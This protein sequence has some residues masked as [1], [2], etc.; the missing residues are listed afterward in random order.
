VVGELRRGYHDRLAAIHDEV[1]GMVRS[2]ASSVSQATDALLEGNVTGAAAV[3]TTAVALSVANGGVEREVFDLVALQAPVARDL[4]LLL[5]SLRV[6]HEVELSGGLASNIA[7]RASLPRET[8]VLTPGLRALL[9]SM[10]AESAALMDRAGRAYV[11]L[12]DDLAVAVA[13]SGSTVRSVHRS[14]LGELF[15][16]PDGPVEPVVDLGIVARCY[17]RIADHALEVADRVRFVVATEA[18]SVGD[19][20]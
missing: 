13:A 7:A 9:Y 14:F 1:S 2:A 15:A 19:P 18:G 4:R 20:G 11:A 6:A 8:A 5:A 3:A 17:E 16:L 12:D 10:G